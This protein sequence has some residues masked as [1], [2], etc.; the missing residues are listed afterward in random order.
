MRIGYALFFVSLLVLGTGL[1]LMRIGNFNLKSP[2]GR[3]TV[4]WMHVIAPLMAV[5]LYWLHRLAGPP[6][7]WRMVLSYMGAVAA[8][9][10]A[11]GS[12]ARRS[13]SYAAAVAAVVVVAMVAYAARRGP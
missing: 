8:A 9:I 12:H 11:R 13:A 6:I 10:A 1:A 4:Y 7:K 2:T 5:W 3:A